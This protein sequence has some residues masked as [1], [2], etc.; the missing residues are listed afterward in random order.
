MKDLDEVK[1]QTINDLIPKRVE[2]SMA[3][4]NQVGL[5]VTEFPGKHIELKGYM[6]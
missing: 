3:A 4:D 5:I 2:S 1:R 6:D